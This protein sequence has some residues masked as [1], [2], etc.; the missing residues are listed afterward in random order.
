MNRGKR[1]LTSGPVLQPDSFRVRLR[2]PIQNTLTVAGT[3]IAKRW[4]P[5]AAYDVDPVLGSTSTPGFA[6]WAGLYT[7][8]RVVK[9]TVHMSFCNLDNL[10]VALMSYHNNVDPGTAGSSGLQYAQSTFGRTYD[11]APFYSGG[12]KVVLN[13]TVKVRDILGMP[14]MQA[15]SFRSLTTSTPSDLVFWGFTILSS[16]G[17][18]FT[19][20][21]SYAGYIEMETIFFSR[22][23]TLTSFLSYEDYEAQ[24]I[25]FKKQQQ[26]RLLEIEARDRQRLIDLEESKRRIEEKVKQLEEKTSQEGTFSEYSP[27]KNALNARGVS[28]AGQ[29]R[30]KSTSVTGEPAN[31]EAVRET[32]CS[33]TRDSGP[34]E[35]RDIDS[36]LLLRKEIVQRLG[37][38]N[39]ILS[40]MKG[41]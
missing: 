11:L 12:G 27:T 35:L 5:N 28:V 30:H 31:A 40:V 17:V 37:Q 32:E 23:D 2:Y 38:L 8:Y 15:D 18:N 39:E 9:Y 25:V 20:G 29:T 16:S 13:Q 10:G 4:Q 14:V 24:R 26:T 41:W 21:I 3:V 6:E 19:N 22:K 36:E 33:D 1:N 34:A 7:Y